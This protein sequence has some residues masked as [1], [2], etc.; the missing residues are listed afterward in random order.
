MI[1]CDV[2]LFQQLFLLGVAQYMYCATPG[3][4][5]QTG[6][7]MLGFKITSLPDLT[8]SHNF[9]TT[10][11]AWKHTGK[12]ISAWILMLTIPSSFSLIANLSLL[13]YYY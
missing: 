9:D 8:G 2:T 7:E 4:K 1:T 3:G 5:S 13:C 11:K 10:P 12:F 6:F